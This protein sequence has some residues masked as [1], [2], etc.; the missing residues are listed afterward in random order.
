MWQGISYQG[1]TGAWQSLSSAGATLSGFKGG[2]LFLEWSGCGYIY[3][4]FADTL[5]L[6]YPFNPKYL[7]LRILVNGV[8]LC[9][10]RGCYTHEH[11]RV[12]G[13]QQFPPGDLNVRF[14]FKVT[15]NGPD[16]A[17]TVSGGNNVMQA[18]LYSNKF[19]AIGRFR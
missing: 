1:A 7:R 6:D 8:V 9:E 3:P 12:F 18:H 2:S 15:P 4:A 10:R 16:D 19:L 13:S 17:L 14:Q 5:A 11:F